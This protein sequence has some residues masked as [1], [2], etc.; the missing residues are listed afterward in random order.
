MKKKINSVV[1]H[2]VMASLLFVS[3]NVWGQSCPNPPNCILNGSLTPRASTS[4]DMNSTSARTIN[5]WFVSHG[6][7]S[8]FPGRTGASGDQS[9]WMWSN[10]DGPAVGEGIFTCYNFVQG[11]TYNIC[12][13][14][15]NTNASTVNGNLVIRAGNN[16][17]P[18]T[19][20]S[21][22][23]PFTTIPPVAGTDVIRDQNTFQT[24]WTL[25]TISNYQPSQNFN[26]LWIYPRKTGGNIQQYEIQVD[27]IA[28]TRMVNQNSILATANPSTISWC[29]TTTLSINGAPAGSTVS[30]SP[31]AGLSAT[32]G[33][34]VTASPCATTT[35]TATVTVTQ[36]N[37]ITC[38]NYSYTYPVTVTVVPPSVTIT[39]NPN[40]ICGDNLSLMASPALSCP[41]ITYSWQGPNGFSTIGAGFSIP[42]PDSRAAGTYTLTVTNGC[43]GTVT[44]TVN[45]T[46]DCPCI[47]KPEIETRGCNPVSFNVTNSSLTN[48]VGWFWEFG[49]GNTSNLAT[50]THLYAQNGSY[51]V[52]VTVIG[53]SPRGE[54]CCMQV[55]DTIQACGCSGAAPW[56]IWQQGRA[57]STTFTNTSLANAN[58]CGWIWDFGDGHT[59]TANNPTHNYTLPGTYTVCLTALTCYLNPS[60]EQT[61]T[62]KSRV[63]QTV[64]ITTDGSWRMADPGSGSGNTS[65][66][67]LNLD[68]KL[69]PNPASTELF[70][71]LPEGITG[72]VRLL[73]VDGKE[74]MR[75]QNNGSNTYTANLKELATGVYLIEVVSNGKAAKRMQFV[76][77]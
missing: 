74:L 71:V 42:S 29:G 24:S 62:C 70:V 50:P 3:G 45:V 53:K 35:Y 19:T 30:W 22:I 36:P 66:D 58:V 57:G 9:V 33:L 32:T 69:F 59:S 56:F 1:R 15:K 67:N 73:S 2:V 8:I 39:G 17:S 41:G 20:I 55:C 21:Q 27:D 23:P 12:L 31:A 46:Y 4:G 37:C 60:T 26:Q 76:K 40:I 68:V 5:D 7:P 25:L 14:V 61:D 72:E 13:W 6:S 11:E 77:E 54:M 10:F 48:I 16:L 52:C 43:G 44:Q 64:V 51:V 49:D 38:G 47:L 63:C 65:D 18:A 28:I 34:S 75:L